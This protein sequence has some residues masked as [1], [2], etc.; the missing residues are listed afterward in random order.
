MSSCS[1][2]TQRSVLLSME[3][4]FPLQ[5]ARAHTHTHTHTHT[6]THTHTVVPCLFSKLITLIYIFFFYWLFQYKY[7]DVRKFPEKNPKACE[8]LHRRVVT[9][10][11]HTFFCYFRFLPDSVQTAVI[12]HTAQLQNTANK[13]C[14]CDGEMQML[15]LDCNGWGW[16][17]WRENR[18][19]TVILT[20][21]RRET[22]GTIDTAER[23]SNGTERDVEKKSET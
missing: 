15:I 5:L 6:E 10:H 8:L 12:A 2:Y 3:T 17:W 22:G 16:W 9:N 18:A 13:R 20:V 11:T 1:N 4:V 19:F 14:V 21:T 23:N 7:T